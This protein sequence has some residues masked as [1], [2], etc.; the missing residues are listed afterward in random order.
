MA[1]YGAYAN[2]EI[3]YNAQN[4]QLAANTV[5]SFRKNLGNSLDSFV[6]LKQQQHQELEAKKKKRA[7]QIGAASASFNDQYLKAKAASDKFTSS[8]AGS[9]DKEVL[10]MSSQIQNAL[11]SVGEKLSIDIE[12]L[13]PDASQ[14][15]IDQLTADAIAEVTRLKT[16][17]ENL[18]GAYQEYEAAK[19]LDPS[20]PKA[21]LGNSNPEMQL[22]FEKLDDKDDN[23]I[24]SQ[25][26]SNGH[27]ILI[28][29]EKQPS[30]ASY[31]ELVDGTKTINYDKGIGII[32]ASD[33]GVNAQKNGGY[34][35]YVGAED[36]GAEVNQFTDAIKQLGGQVS[37]VAV[38]PGQQN[39]N[40]SNRKKTYIKY[41]H[42]A[43]NNYLTNNPKFKDSFRPF[44]VDAALQQ[45]MNKSI[46]EIEKG[47]T[48]TTTKTLDDL[49]LEM[50]YD[51]L[52]EKSLVK[53]P[54]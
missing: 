40:N 13:G 14:F 28:P 43:I 11:Y 32:D 38:L 50:Y 30:G 7:Q 15:K 29:V 5:Q 21:I 8:I 20:D 24:L 22:L 6:Q 53:L 45:I 47:L 25:D 1:D 51:A 3:L 9:G 42:G 12:S 16:D 34:F 10:N 54:Q 49:K 36:F 39:I 27:W 26:P 41:D 23:V 44:N 35:N 2:P 17:M 48:A 18:Y 37:S 19:D 52:I 4:A 46:Y 31:T 33:F